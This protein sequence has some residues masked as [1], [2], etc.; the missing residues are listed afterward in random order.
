[1]SLKANVVVFSGAPPC[2]SSALLQ[3]YGRYRGVF[4]GFRQES[5]RSGKVLVLA[6]PD[7]VYL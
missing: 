6:I 5:I 1:M 7:T 4:F 2:P 3:I